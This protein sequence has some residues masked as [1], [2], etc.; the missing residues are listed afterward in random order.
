MLFFRALQQLI[1]QG[2]SQAVTS[3]SAS[4]RIILLLIIFISLNVSASLLM[5]QSRLDLTENNLYT[6]NAGS[7]QILDALAEPIQLDFYYSQTLASQAPAM[8]LAA[9]RVRDLLDEI[10]NASHGKIT[11]TVIDP[12][13]FSDIEDVAISRGLVGRALPSGDLFYFGLVGTN[14]VDSTEIISS[15]PQ[16]R[17]Q[18]LEYDL[19]RLID[20][21]NTPRKPILGVMSNL[22]LDTGAGGLLAAMRGQSQPFLIY[23]ELVDR[24]KVEFLPPDTQKISSKIDVLLL[25]HPRELAAPQL[26]AIDQF[27]MRGGRL[28]VFIDPYSEVSL[29]AGPNGAPL[30]GYTDQSDLPQLLSHW[31]I[32]YHP[33][34]IVADKQFAQRVAAGGDARRQL[35]DY[36]LWMGM[37]AEAFNQTDVILS[38]IDLINIGS[39][40]HFTYAS[41]GTETIFTPLISSSPDSMLLARDQVVAGP[42][43]DDLLR[44]FKPSEMRYTLAGRL[45][46]II[47]S[48]FEGPPEGAK[49][50]APHLTQNENANIILM[51]DSDFFD[52]RFWVTE[53]V[54]LGQ[55]FA[56][57]MADNAKFLMNAVEN[58]MGS[59][60]LISLRG[61]ERALR[62]FSRVDQIRRAAEEEFLA[63]E[64]E[65]HAR[66][67]AAQGE[68]DRLEQS[69]AL[70]EAA[71][72]VRTRYRL[73]LQ[74]ARKALRQ[75]QANLRRDIDQLGTTIRWLNITVM[76][77]FIILL[78]LVVMWRRRRRRQATQKSGGFKM[79]GDEV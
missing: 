11:L 70:G 5:R 75:V 63:E 23:A 50:G 47:R 42:R 78:S 15:F 7:R 20:N 77:S 49:T 39:V 79:V 57:P 67:T 21:L 41:T 62:S 24:F 71:V 60:A 54:Y 8:R 17:E 13:P 1:Q 61:R 37:G 26:Y 56:V 46:G 52:D 29:T 18:Y 33:Q 76:P 59:D 44:D 32:G 48:A 22:P 30:A 53:Q 25:A 65:L 45:H 58:M 74:A 27:V 12:E 38:N 16:E 4:L 68:L 51:A 55:R 69:S 66:I 73:E 34:E 14:R 19:I 35:V 72:D 64:Q 31:G 43:P 40:G 28:I 36:V 9:Q 10:V 6:L 2:A 3:S